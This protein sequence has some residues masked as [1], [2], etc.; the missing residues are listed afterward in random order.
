[1]QQERLGRAVQFK[2]AIYLEL[3]KQLELAKIE[4]VKN[5]SVVNVLDGG[6]TPARKERPKRLLNTLLTLL[7]TMGV[8]AGYY[9]LRP[10]F[11]SYRKT[12]WSTLKSL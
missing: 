9:G 2:S 1:M 8:S 4:E 7:V 11:E 3:K 12:L 6:S 10:S 5:V